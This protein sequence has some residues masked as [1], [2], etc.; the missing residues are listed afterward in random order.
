MFNT[1]IPPNAVSYGRFNQ[2]RQSC[3]CG[4]GSVDHSDIVNASSLHPGGANFTMADGSVR[5]IKETI[6]MKIYWA[7]GTKDVGEVFD[8][9]NY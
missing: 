4:L 1:L 3:A 8:Q 2:C 5:F 6:Q 7:L 9:G